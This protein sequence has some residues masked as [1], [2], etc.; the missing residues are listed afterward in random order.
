MAAVGRWA[1]IECTARQPRNRDA[2]AEAGKRAD[3]Q[4]RSRRPSGRGRGR[5]ANAGPKI[6]AQV[7]WGACA[8]F[9]AFR[10][11][12]YRKKSGHEI[13]ATK[14]AAQ[15]ASMAQFD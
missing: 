13:I 4:D 1:V 12:S 5:R 7:R 15:K 10:V 9:V 8:A 6:R 2:C 11:A 14:M 3:D